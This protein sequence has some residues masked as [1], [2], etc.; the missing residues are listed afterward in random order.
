[1]KLQVNNRK[2]E[3]KSEVKTIRREGNIPAIVY[4]RG[5]DGET[6]S[7]N[8]VEFNALLRKVPSGRLST[9][10]FELEEKGAKLRRSILKD[11]TYDPVSYQVIHLDFEELNPEAHI[12]VKVPIELVGVVDCVG[13]KLGG[14]LRQVIRS[15]RVRCLPKD[16]PTHFQV[17]VRNMG[18]NEAVRLENLEIP[19]NVRPLMDQ[20]EVIVVIGKR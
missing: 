17:D 19:S 15:L 6:L 7:V 11:I 3:K 18:I 1:M 8:G 13:V 12:T 5:K 9:T 2:A 20:N 14:V 4:L 16:L 10:V